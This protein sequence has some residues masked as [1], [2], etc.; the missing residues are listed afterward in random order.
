L[1][2]AITAEQAVQQAL[3]TESPINPRDANG[4]LMP[5]NPAWSSG[6]YSLQ[7]A[8]IYLDPVCNGQTASNL[9]LIQTSTGL[10]LSTAGIVEGAVGVAA[11]S[12]IGLA[13][14]GVG[15]A[16]GIV[17][18]IF[19]HHAAAVKRDIGAE[20]SAVPAANNALQV[21]IQ[22]VQQGLITP[23][24]GIA[25]LN[26]LPPAFLQAV[27]PAKNNSP[28]CNVLCEKLITLRAICFYWIAQFQD[29]QSQQQSSSAQ[30]SSNPVA[31]VTSAVS[32]AAASVGIPSWALWLAGGFVFYKLAT[33]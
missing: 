5:T 26:S 30:A 31:A 13:T 4:F 32:S 6:P 29:L 2:G 24:Q 18:A 8:Q 1:L 23:Q 28:Y 11:T 15:A 19:Q 7:S 10:A 25:E 33:N 3:A 17:F 16:V 20:C 14:F 22:G 21:I 12:V 27:G 9:Q